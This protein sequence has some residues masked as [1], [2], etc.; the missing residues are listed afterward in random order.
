MK[1]V[2]INGIAYIGN[3]EEKDGKTVL[4]DAMCLKSPNFVTKPDIANYLKKENLGELEN[5]EFG[6][7]GVSYSISELNDEEKLFFEIASVTMKSAK[8]KAV[9][10]LENQVFDEYLGK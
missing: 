3:L 5:V 10:G 4:K 1:K 6:G 7:Q 9:N 2:T 8:L